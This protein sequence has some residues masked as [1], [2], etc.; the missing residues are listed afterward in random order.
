MNDQPESPLV[1][2]AKEY[3][4]RAYAIPVLLVITLWI[5]VDVV[6]GQGV[7]EEQPQHAGAQTSAS[8]MNVESKDSRGSGPIPADSAPINLPTGALP[9]GGPYTARGDKTFRVVGAPGPKVGE[10]K[11]KQITYV[12]EVENGVDTAA[13]G[14][15]QAV[16]AM[17]DATLSNPKG[18]IADKAFSFQH[19]RADENPT[20]R[21]QLT[22]VETTHE[23][24]GADLAM[25][26]SCYTADGNRVVL[27]ESRWVRG[28]VTSQGDIGGYRQY[29]INHEVGHGLG[30]AEHAACP[31]SGEL[32]P[33]MMQQTL[34][35]DN[36][37]LHGIDP[38]E[39]Y[40]DDH[41]ACTFNPWPF[42]RS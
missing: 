11:E 27:N 28:A 2:F 4:W 9:D 33:I 42:P 31:K 41:N 38:K 3:G 12:V 21:I 19:V 17:I 36:S 15:D 29:L 7:P 18:W 6:R 35:L 8:S 40:P 5:I 34:S 30:Y 14:G 16:A 23:V 26:T 24:C 22:S 37:V 32:A 10:G 13:Y 1:R 20:M 25:E 39:I